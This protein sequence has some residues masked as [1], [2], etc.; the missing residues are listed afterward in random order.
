MADEFTAMTFKGSGPFL[1]PPAGGPIK[2]A[3]IETPTEAPNEYL[4]EWPLP[5]VPGQTQ[6]IV[7]LPVSA[8]IA[9]GLM[10]VL[11]KAQKELGLPIPIGRFSDR[12]FQ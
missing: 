7:Q 2:F 6:N 11:E 3:V 12:R 5:E 9:M 1:L 8:E 10:L 4:L